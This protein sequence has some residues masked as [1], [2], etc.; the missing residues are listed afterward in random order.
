MPCLGHIARHIYCLN[1]ANTGDV[2]QQQ[3]CRL[4]HPRPWIYTQYCKITNQANRAKRLRLRHSPL[5]QL[6]CVKMFSMHCTL[7][8]GCSERKMKGGGEKKSDRDRDREY[9]WESS[10]TNPRET[11][12][13]YPL[14]VVVSGCRSTLNDSLKWWSRVTMC[15]S[16]HIIRCVGKET[17]KYMTVQTHA[18][19]CS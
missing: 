1:K 13:T 11:R 18:H 15:P 2:A 6:G 7:W 12:N 9:E 16:S 14:Y 10:I 8:G 5:G 17:G 3:S 19:I 4:T